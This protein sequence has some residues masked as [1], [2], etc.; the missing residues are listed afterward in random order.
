ML[1]KALSYWCI[2]ITITM[3]HKRLPHH[4]IL[5]LSFYFCCGTDRDRCPAGFDQCRWPSTP[6]CFPMHEFPQDNVVDRQ[7]WM[8]HAA[9]GRAEP[10]H[11]D[12][13]WQSWEICHFED[14]PVTN[15]TFSN[16]L[17]NHY[18][19]YSILKKYANSGTPPVKTTRSSAYAQWKVKYRGLKILSY[20][21][22]KRD[23][24]IIK[25]MRKHDGRPTVTCF[26]VLRHE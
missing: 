2:T 22:H 23:A 18:F 16:Y 9:S 4:A 8:P 19:L 15:A 6:D 3:S 5:H 17:V 13:S 20:R 25:I 1:F 21:M 10:P 11:P 26:R 12:V 7:F 14:H 24:K